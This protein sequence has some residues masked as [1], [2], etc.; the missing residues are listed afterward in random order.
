MLNGT[1]PGRGRRA[2]T[3]LAVALFLSAGCK[4]NGEQRPSTEW[5]F[6]DSES[7]SRQDIQDQRA[8]SLAAYQAS[9]NRK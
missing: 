5:G 2:T 7:L 4:W 3:W 6:P 9:L 8:R 1:D